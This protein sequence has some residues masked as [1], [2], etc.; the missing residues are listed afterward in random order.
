[1]SS[2][3]KPTLDAVKAVAIPILKNK[4]INPAANSKFW[5]PLKGFVYFCKNP[6]LWPVVMMP[7]C[8]AILINLI[9]FIVIFA[10]A[11][12]PQAI[13]FQQIAVFA[14]GQDLFPLSFVFATIL[15]FLESLLMVVITANVVLGHWG[16]KL[17]QKTLELEGCGPAR[18][19]SCSEECSYSFWMEMMRLSLFIVLLPLHLVPCLGTIAFAYI[20]G[21]SCVATAHCPRASTRRYFLEFFCFSPTDLQLLAGWDYHQEFMVQRLGLNWH[22]QWD[23]VMARKSDY[24]YFG[25][26]CTLLSLVPLLNFV[27][28]FTNNVGA[29]IWA[30]N[31][32][33][34][35][36][37][38]QEAGKASSP[39]PA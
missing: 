7:L 1:M 30:A 26:G 32:Y 13:A 6:K 22:E 38:T 20:N 33:K 2:S 15:C 8:C 3:T 12:A 34:E 19:L 24:T 14:P 18:D 37:A 21:V 10:V 4:D 9:G 39:S 5:L 25:F 17:F 23:Y 31:L 28:C 16:G 11:L 29:A 36:A 35:M 27:F